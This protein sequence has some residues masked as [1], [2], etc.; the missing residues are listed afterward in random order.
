MFIVGIGVGFVNHRRS[1]AAAVQIVPGDFIHREDAVLGAGFDGHIAD[2]KTVI[3]GKSVDA[4]P[5][6]FHALVERTVHADFADDREDHILAAA[7]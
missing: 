7:I 1:F 2:A 4:F 5:G 3:H 6:E